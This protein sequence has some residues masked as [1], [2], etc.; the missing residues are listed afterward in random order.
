[1]FILFYSYSPVNVTLVT[2]TTKKE[3]C[4]ES[5][6]VN[7]ICVASDANRAVTKYQLL[8]NGEVLNNENG[9]WIKKIS[10]GENYVSSCLA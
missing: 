9:T 8:G 7:F 5:M 4:P 6:W 1:M 3:D 2:N 10:E